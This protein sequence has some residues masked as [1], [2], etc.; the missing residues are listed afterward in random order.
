M[1]NKEMIP[2]RA[3][4]QELATGAGHRT[5][6]DREKDTWWALSQLARGATYRDI[7]KQLSE[8]NG[9]HIAFQQ[10]Y[11]DIQD[12]MVKWKRENMENVE[13]YIAAECARLEEIEQRVLAD[14][15]KSKLPSPTEYAAMIKR[16]LTPA[17]VDELYKK[18]G[19]R[20]GDPRYLDTLLRLQKQRLDL[21][22]LNRGNDI[23][24]STVV[25]YN[26]GNAS[27]EELSRMADMLQDQKTDEQ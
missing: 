14:Y 20:A 19:G 17:E 22:G 9:Y 8:K 25:N 23:P 26:F 12:E 3:T 5:A 4:K 15:E 21:L 18:R 1:D 6:L 27:M 10:V 2:E 16:G 13:A 24:S 11:R 7:A